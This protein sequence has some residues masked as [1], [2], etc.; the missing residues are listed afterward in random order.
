MLI[1]LTASI[2]VMVVSAGYVWYL[3]LQAPEGYEDQAGFH[4]TAESE[5]ALKKAE[6]IAPT[7]LKAHDDHEPIAA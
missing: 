2:L 6:Q 1:V 4:Q 7:P 5:L 3:S